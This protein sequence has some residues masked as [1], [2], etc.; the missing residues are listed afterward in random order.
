MEMSVITY[1]ASALID[2]RSQGWSPNIC[3]VEVMLCMYVEHMN[4]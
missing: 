4:V 1:V 2:A 3:S